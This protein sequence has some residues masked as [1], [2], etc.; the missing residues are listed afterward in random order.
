MKL[1][2]DASDLFQDTDEDIF[3]DIKKDVRRRVERNAELMHTLSCAKIPVWRGTAL[4]NQQWSVGT[5]ATGEVEA[6]GG[7]KDPGPT[8]TM[9]VG[10]EPRRPENQRVAD[11]SFTSLDFTNPFQVFWLTNN[12]PHMRNIEYGLPPGPGLRAR[13]PKGVFRL[14]AQEVETAMQAERF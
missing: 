4:A 5:P 11:M 10:T 14:S 8:N 13:A 3:E 12:T 9:R 6:A 2:I 1:K 7:D